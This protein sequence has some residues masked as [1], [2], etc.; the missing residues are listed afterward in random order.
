MW[1]LIS[2]SS[3]WM[4]RAISTLSAGWPE[5]APGRRALQLL[6]QLV[7]LGPEPTLFADVDRA[8]RGFEPFEQIFVKLDITSLLAV[9]PGGWVVKRTGRTARQRPVRA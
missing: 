2:S 6:A 3:A 8:D 4:R 9:G 5:G 1:W 7:V